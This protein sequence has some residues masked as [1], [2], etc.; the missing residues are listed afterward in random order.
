[1]VYVTFLD[2]EIGPVGLRLL[3]LQFGCRF[4][5]CNIT[6]FAGDYCCLKFKL[7]C[8]P[9]WLVGCLYIYIY[10]FSFYFKSIVIFNFTF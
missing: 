1:M 10:I 5:G 6:C 7:I 4:F 8:R 9:Y 2:L 3:A